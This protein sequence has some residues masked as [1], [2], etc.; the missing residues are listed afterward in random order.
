MT[1]ISNILVPVDFSAASFALRAS[2]YCRCRSS[3]RRSLGLSQWPN[4]QR[5]DK[6]HFNRDGKP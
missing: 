6:T 5:P 3:Y 2:R 1:R 4:L